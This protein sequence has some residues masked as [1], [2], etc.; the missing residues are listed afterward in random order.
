MPLFLLFFSEVDVASPCGNWPGFLF[1]R[2]LLFLTGVVSTGV[3]GTVAPIPALSNLWSNMTLVLSSFLSSSVL[4]STMSSLV[5]SSTLSS[6]CNCMR[7]SNCFVWEVTDL[8]FLQ[9]VGTLRGVSWLSSNFLYS[10]SF[11]L[12]A[13]ALLSQTNVSTR[14]GRN[15]PKQKKI[16][17]ENIAVMFSK[18][19]FK[20]SS[21]TSSVKG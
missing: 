3:V 9:E 5:L 13:A 21:F 20:K 7:E 17:G 16:L 12:G 8:S 19:L 4:S 11:T 6:S 2:L 14:D 15:L 18:Q 10:S 1:C